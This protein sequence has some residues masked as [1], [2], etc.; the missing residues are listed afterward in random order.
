M[1]RTHHII[2]YVVAGLFFISLPLHA[3]E[4]GEKSAKKLFEDTCS[5]CHSLALPRSQHLNRSNW[6][7]VMDDMVNEF[8]CPLTDVVLQKKVI[9]YLVENYGPEK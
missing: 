7:W 5:K 8:G 4:S 3:N 2:C 6:E 9:D 1:R